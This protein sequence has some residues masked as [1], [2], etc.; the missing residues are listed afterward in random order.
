VSVVD[1][2][3]R[4]GPP[5]RKGEQRSS[6]LR[7]VY[8]LAIYVGDELDEATALQDCVARLL[9]RRSRTAPRGSGYVVTLAALPEPEDDD[10]FIAL[11]TDGTQRVLLGPPEVL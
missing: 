11:V 9:H 10:A 5:A 3:W 4:Y 6:R 7:I 8:R 1:G 2:F